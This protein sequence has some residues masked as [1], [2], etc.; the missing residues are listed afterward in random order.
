MIWLML[1]MQ[2]VMGPFTSM[3]AC[4]HQLELLGQRLPGLTC[5]RWV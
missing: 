5:E 3:T 1:G 2:I 4:S